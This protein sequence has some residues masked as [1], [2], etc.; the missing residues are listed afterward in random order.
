MK[1]NI[2]SLKPGDNFKLS[3]S[4][5]VFTVK[6][7]FKKYCPTLGQTLHIEAINRSQNDKTSWFIRD[8]PV[9]VIK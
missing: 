7:Y 8:F 9:E 2:F 4:E 5:D 6:R 3:T 1:K